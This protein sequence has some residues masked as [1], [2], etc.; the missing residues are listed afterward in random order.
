MTD[1]GRPSKT[2][3]EKL[4]KKLNA[5]VTPAE[6]SEI[7]GFVRGQTIPEAQLI[8]KAVLTYIR[9]KKNR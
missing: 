6:K 3:S 1:K 9:D 2:A 8:R 5:Y 4:S 7:E